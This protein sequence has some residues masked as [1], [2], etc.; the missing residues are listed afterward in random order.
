MKPDKEGIMYVWLVDDSVRI[1]E[2][3][4]HHMLSFS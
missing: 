2:F 3:G 4:I 1:V